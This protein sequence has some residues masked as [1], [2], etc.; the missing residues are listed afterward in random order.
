MSTKMNTLFL[1]TFLACYLAGVRGDVE[2]K[3]RVCSVNQ[4]RQVLDLICPDI[5]RT[6]HYSSEVKNNRL[7]LW[8]NIFHMNDNTLG[9]F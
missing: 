4:I 3:V 7:T 8:K 2:K 9:E 5:K 1:L 6:N